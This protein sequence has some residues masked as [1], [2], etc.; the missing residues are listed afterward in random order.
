MRSPLAGESILLPFPSDVHP[1]SSE[2]SLLQG[3]DEAAASFRVV[4][5]QH[6]REGRSRQVRAVE[7]DSTRKIWQEHS[8]QTIKERIE[9]PPEEVMHAGHRM[10]CRYKGRSQAALLLD[11]RKMEFS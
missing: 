2:A 11:T 3:H 1:D 10:F 8:W 4:Y 6:R 7:Y 5:L 9:G